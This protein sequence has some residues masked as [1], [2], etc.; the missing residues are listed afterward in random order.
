[1]KLVKS[2]D[3]TNDV[4]SYSG[5]TYITI[6]NAK[7]SDSSAFHHLCVMNRAHP[8]PE[9]TKSFQNQHSR[10]KK[11]MIVRVDG[12]PDENPRNSNTINC[13]IEYFCG[14]NLDAY[15]VATNGLGR[16]AFNRVERRM[17]NLS[18]ELSG[19]ILPHDHFGNHLDHNNNTIDEELE[20]QNFEYAG[21]RWRRGGEGESLH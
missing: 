2:K 21:E 7:H 15:F 12:G 20:L 11:V 1:M 4:V 8:F 10:E 13:A 17:S 5:P 14:H 6:R 3:L 16:S 18:K 9:F 19:V